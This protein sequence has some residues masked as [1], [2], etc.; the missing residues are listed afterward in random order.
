MHE[1]IH[2]DFS[3]LFVCCLNRAPVFTMKLLMLIIHEGGSMVCGIFCILNGCW[4]IAT[5]CPKLFGHVH[6]NVS[7]V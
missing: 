7:E 4:V 5:N 2:D 1:M 3:E 6:H